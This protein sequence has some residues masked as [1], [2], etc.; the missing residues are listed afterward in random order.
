[1]N[2]QLSCLEAKVPCSLE[3]RQFYG[4]YFSGQGKYAY[5]TQFLGRFFSHPN[6]RVLL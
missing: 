4:L 3:R 1:M 5:F 6:L 2:E